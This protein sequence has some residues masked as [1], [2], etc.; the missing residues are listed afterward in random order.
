MFKIRFIIPTMGRHKGLRITYDSIKRSHK[1]CEIVFITENKMLKYEYDD[2]IVKECPVGTKFTEKINMGLA[3]VINRRS[4]CDAVCLLNDDVILFPTAMKSIVD[5]FYNGF[6]GLLNPFSNCDRG[7]LHEIAVTIEDKELGIGLPIEWLNERRLKGLEVIS[8][9]LKVCPIEVVKHI[10]FYSTF[11]DRNTVL[12]LGYL[13]ESLKTTHS[14]FEYCDRAKEYGFTVAW[15]PGAF[16]FH[17]GAVSRKIDEDDSHANYHNTEAKDKKKYSNRKKEIVLISGQSWEKWGVENLYKG[18]IGGSETCLIH[19]GRQLVK[20]G[21]KVTSVIDSEADDMKDGVEYISYDSVSL[22]ELVGDVLISSR[23]PGVIQHCG[24]FSK[25]VLWCHDIT[26]PEGGIK[27]AVEYDKIVLLSDWHEEFWGKYGY[28]DKY[29][30]IPNGVD[31]GRFKQKDRRF[32]RFIWGSSWDRGLDNLLF[33]L[34]NVRGITKL[35]VRLDV[36]YGDYNLLKTAEKTNNDQLKKFH[37]FI[38]KAIESRPW[39]T[40]HDRLDQNKLAE[41]YSKSYAWLYPTHFSETF[42]IT[43]LEAMAAGLPIIHNGYA[44]LSRFKDTGLVIDNYPGSMFFD[45]MKSNA[46]A[47]YI[48]AG[49][50]ILSDPELWMQQSRVSLAKAAQYSW[51][52]VVKKYWVPLIE[53]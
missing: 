47:P 10:A 12:S 14:D 36:Y 23:F 16:I 49:V 3:D 13:D 39:I 44:G 30:V 45:G 26:F 17:F 53:A 18:G 41:E 22:H 4:D 38:M 34:S 27:A 6:E 11:I 15:N 51:D 20:N 5:K 40:L 25:S 8:K 1:D 21:Y 42:C 28:N 50:K 24:N 35:D 32:G 31:L 33:I 52:E 29:T 19:L 46:L 43:A 7:W 9:C 48:D 37:E 2:V